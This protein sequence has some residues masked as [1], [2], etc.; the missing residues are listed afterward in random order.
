MRKGSA[1][2]LAVIVMASLLA[3][4]AILLKIVYNG[5]ATVGAL[6]E[7]EQAF[8]LAEA[9]LE[10]GKVELKHNPAWYTDL[11]HGPTDDL[12]WL[13]NSAVG[14]K[15]ALGRGWYKMVRERDKQSIYSVGGQGKARVILKMG[16]S[17]PLKFLSWEEI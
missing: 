11:S 4:G 8:W 3:L 7:R 6:I 13:K 12:K 5:H 2:L 15:Q 10:M 16:F 17:A 14:K 1:L 9:G